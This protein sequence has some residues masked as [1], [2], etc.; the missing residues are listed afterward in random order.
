MAEDRNRGKELRERDLPQGGAPPYFGAMSS[1]SQG[2][3][4]APSLEPTL[5]SAGVPGST[6]ENHRRVVVLSALAI[7]VGFAGAAAAEVLLK[8]IAFVTNLSFYGHP[9][10]ASVSPADNA[11]GLWV[12]RSEE[13]RVGKECR[14]R[15]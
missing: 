7:L 8:L 3:P 12:M 2:V 15:W 5:I 1:G 14:S 13:R 11:L 9:S 10:A 4:V 6:S